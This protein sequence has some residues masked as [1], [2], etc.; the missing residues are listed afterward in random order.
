MAAAPA[1]GVNESYYGD[2][3][4]TIFIGDRGRV[5]ERLRKAAGGGDGEDEDKRDLD[6]DN[7]KTDGDSEN[8]G[9]DKRIAT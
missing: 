2:S 8:G 4:D 1:R 3:K 6:D 9:G 5:L 7:H